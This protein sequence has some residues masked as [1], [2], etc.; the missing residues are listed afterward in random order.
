MLIAPAKAIGGPTMIWSPRD[1]WK[2]DL[3][4][5]RKSVVSIDSQ[6]PESWTPLRGGHRRGGRSTKI[7]RPT[8]KH[9]RTRHVIAV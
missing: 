4:S 7:Q 2:S 6:V 1:R 9:R 8:R 3:V 5:L